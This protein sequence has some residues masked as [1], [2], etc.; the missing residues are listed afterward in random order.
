MTVCR[1]KYVVFTHTHAR[2]I[3]RVTQSP[4][5][6]VTLKRLRILGNDVKCDVTFQ[7][8]NLEHLI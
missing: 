3:S 7:H 6:G 2:T 8:R 5:K 4:Q 1:M